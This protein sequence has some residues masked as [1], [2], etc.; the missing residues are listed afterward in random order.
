MPRWKISPFVAAPVL[1]DEPELDKLDMMDICDVQC[2]PRRATCIDDS[3]ME[4]I[5]RIEGLD[6]LSPDAAQFLR[7]RPDQARL[8]V[9]AALE[10]AASQARF[11]PES[12]SHREE[13]PPAHLA[14]FVVNR[15]RDGSLINVSE[16]AAR[17]DVSRTTVYDWVARR[18]LLAWK[19]TRRGL[20][21]PAEQIV[22]PGKVVPGLD[23]LAET[24]DD[25]ELA[26]AFLSEP[27]P[28]SDREARPIDLLK[29]GDVDTVLD[30]APAFGTAMS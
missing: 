20:I 19:T 3:A 13:A 6:G 8:A 2:P 11:E 18:T 26:W 5:F 28:F 16:A 17:L 10:A 22:G 14:A 15:P 30:A 12:A 27:W 24:I 7:R 23:R 4:P 9:V 25:G 1:L 29:A 21:I